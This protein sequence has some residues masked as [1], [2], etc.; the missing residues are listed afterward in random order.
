MLL[1]RNTAWTRALY[2]DVRTMIDD[3]LIVRKVSQLFCI[4]S[5]CSVGHRVPKLSCSLHTAAVWHDLLLQ[6]CVPCLTDGGRPGAL[7]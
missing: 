2:S 7:P 1:L 5:S 4:Y 6:D 3:P